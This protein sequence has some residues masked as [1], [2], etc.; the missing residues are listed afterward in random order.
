MRKRNIGVAVL[1][2]ATAAATAAAVA[3]GMNPPAENVAGAFV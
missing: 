1:T 3:M 2:A